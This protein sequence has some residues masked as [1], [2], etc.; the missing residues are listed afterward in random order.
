MMKDILRY[1]FQLLVVFTVFSISACGDIEYEAQ[2][3]NPVREGQF[4]SG[5]NFETNQKQTVNGLRYETE[6]QAGVTESNGNYKFI[7]QEYITF[8]LGNVKLGDKVRAEKYMSPVNIVPNA[9]SVD[10]ERVTNITRLL[11]SVGTVSGNTIIIPASVI[12]VIEAETKVEN[13]TDNSIEY[14]INFD[15]QET[16][17]KVSFTGY[18]DKIIK[19]LNDNSGSDTYTLVTTTVAQGS[20]QQ[21]L[22]QAEEESEDDDDQNTND[23]EP[24]S[25]TITTHFVN[26]PLAAYFDRPEAVFVNGE[27]VT[28][29]SNGGFRKNETLRPNQVNT[30]T[31]TAT[32]Y[33]M[34]IGEKRFIIRHAPIEYAPD[35]QIL[36]S[37][38][39][40]SSIAETI[41]IDLEATKSN[42]KNGVVVGYIPDVNIVGCSNDNRFLVDDTGKVYFS[43]TH[44]AVGEPLPFSLTGGSNFYPLFSPDDHYC[45]AGTIKID[46]EVWKAIYVDQTIVD[47]TWVYDNFPVYVDSR[48]ATITDNERYLFQ[49][50]KPIEQIPDPLNASKMMYKLAVKVDLLTDYLVENIYINEEDLIAR[51]SLGDMIVSSDGDRGFLT[52]FSGNYSSLDIIDLV[53][54]TVIKGIQ[55][56]S[57]YPGNTIFIKDNSQILFACAGNSWY[58]GGNVTIIST[59]GELITP[60]NQFN[61]AIL[62]YG[63]DD[64]GLYGRSCGQYGAYAV[65]RD[66]ADLLYISSRYIRELGSQKEI[67]NCSPDRRGIDQLEI[68]DGGNFKYNQT[69]FLNAADQKTMHFIKGK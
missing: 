11:L 35:H 37:Y 7:D 27:R 44:Q 4:I 43:S 50:N 3:T 23:N 46:F 68:L 15:D 53:S 10:N 62:Q 22:V 31:I 32:R 12:S 45:Y 20:L 39:V 66:R 9:I 28:T 52:T 24:G 56:L 42:G 17:E 5:Y 65:A 1:I 67:R 8:Y 54:K 19:S 36:Y 25:Y 61:V 30:F 48:Y 13:T 60:L 49:T 16:D 29:V 21:G 6:T 33:N 14:V 63:H 58:G 51:E 55:G 47:G 40:D 18:A 59:D 69:F 2:K 38:S 26:Y 64:C 41:V 57:D 34:P